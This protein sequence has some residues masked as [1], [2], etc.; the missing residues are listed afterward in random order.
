MASRQEEVPARHACEIVFG[1]G[2]WAYPLFLIE[3]IA[4]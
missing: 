4:Y 3:V 1:T 2:I